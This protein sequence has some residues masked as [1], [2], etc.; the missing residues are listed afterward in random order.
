[1]E[2]CC[3]AA[4]AYRAPFVSGKDSLNNEY[5][6]NDGQRHAV[7]PT[8]VITAIAH[9]PDADACITADLDE[10]GNVLMLLGSTRAEFAGSHLDLV[11]G[12][13]ERAGC[14]PAPDHGALDR[15]RRLHAAIRAGLVRSC[16]DLSEGG[17]AVAI[18]EMCIAGR[19]GATIDA[20]PH[21]DVVV[22]MF[23]ESVGRLLVE[24]A[25]ADVDAF[26]DIMG[27]EAERI[28]VVNHDQMLD[29]V[30]VGRIELDD[31]VEVF[32]GRSAR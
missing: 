20:L 1:V 25:P 21:D 24:V 14:V 5:L 10:A 31:L 28:G 4:A 8:L 3:E 13:P 6:G 12:A 19:L 22:A 26:I 15:Y 32:T 29:I 18:A 11:N 23:S 17:F 16:H 9:V 2:G 7:P 27:T 30:G